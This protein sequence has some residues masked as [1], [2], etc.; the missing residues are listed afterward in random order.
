MCLA[1]WPAQSQGGGGWWVG[2]NPSAAYSLADEGEGRG[3]KFLL[4]QWGSCHVSKPGRIW[5]PSLSGSVQSPVFIGAMG[6]PHFLLAFC[7]CQGDELPL[8]RPL[9]DTGRYWLTYL[10]LQ[11]A[12]SLPGLKGTSRL[13]CYNLCCGCF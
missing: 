5:E 2:D 6:V 12:C 10:L 7:G 1:V 3:L 8:P 4:S 13:L 11:E 9:L